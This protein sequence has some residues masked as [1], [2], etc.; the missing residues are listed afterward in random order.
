MT[1]LFGYL[2]GRFATHPENLAIE[3]LAYTLRNSRTARL[4]FVAHLSEFVPSLPTDLL[5]AAR[6]GIVNFGRSN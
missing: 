2:L 3:A 1:S 5:L 6:D 4:A